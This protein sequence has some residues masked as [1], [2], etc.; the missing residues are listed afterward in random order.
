[1][2]SNTVPIYRQGRKFYVSTE[3]YERICSEERKQ[4]RTAILKSQQLPVSKSYQTSIRS[5]STFSYNPIQRNNSNL[6]DYKYG[7]AKTHQLPVNSLLNTD[8]QRESNRL[9]RSTLKHYDS[10]DDL[11]SI[12]STTSKTKPSTTIRSYSSDKVLDN[13]RTPLLSKTDNTIKRSLSDESTQ[14]QSLVQ[15]Q[16][17]KQQ[18]HISS[19]RTI[20][21][22]V[23]NYGMS[24]RTTFSIT[25]TDQ[26]YTQ[27]N[28]STLT[29]YL[30]RIK[31]PTL[32]RSSKSL[33]LSNPATGT[34]FETSMQ[35]FDNVYTILGSSNRLSGTISSSL[36]TS[37][38]TNNSKNEYYYRDTTNGSFSDENSSTLS[39]IFQQQNTDKNNINRQSE[40][41]DETNDNHSQQRDSWT[42]S[43]IRSPSS[44]GITEKKRVR[45]ADTEGFTLEVIS[46]KNQ[47]R[48]TKTNRLL[49]KR[50]SMQNSSDSRDQKQPFH[51]AFYQVTTKLG[52][53]KLATDV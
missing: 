49:T 38:I 31:H 8:N 4:R 39:M 37:S 44:D 43:T 27:T 14:I 2:T 35:G 46:D 28:T 30:A 50:E 34:L 47:L 16:K 36:P 52:R 20:S 26:T 5:P 3:E 41:V 53:S 1:M 13:R 48:S 9:S 7:V 23:S 18:S 24:P 17:P 32:N 51:N 42:R 25:P 10:Q 11:S 21:R 29:S 6:Y 40:Y 19:H 22:T 15:Q 12:T 33:Q 45:F